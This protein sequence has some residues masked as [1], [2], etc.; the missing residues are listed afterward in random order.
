MSNWQGA[1]S[2]AGG[3]AELAAYLQLSKEL[4]IKTIGSGATTK[5]HVVMGNEA[6]DLD[7]VVSAIVYA[8]MLGAPFHGAALDVSSLVRVI[9]I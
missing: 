7:S 6:C 1:A 4:F 3:A 9:K 8:R 2:N 5:I